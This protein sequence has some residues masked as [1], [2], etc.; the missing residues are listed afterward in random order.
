MGSGG[1]R[2]FSCGICKASNRRTGTPRRERPPGDKLST[3]P[4]VARRV[5][6]SSHPSVTHTRGEVAMAA[7]RAGGQEVSREQLITLLNDDLAREYLAVIGY[8]VYSQVIKGAQ[9]MHIAQVLEE[10]A[11][12]ELAHAFIGAKQIDYLGGQP[13]MQPK[14]LLTSEAR[15]AV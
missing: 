11:R 6:C 2:T 9:Y 10:H 14:T 15:P 13:I 12:E 7:Q 3:G 4:V 5:H 8:V 1:C